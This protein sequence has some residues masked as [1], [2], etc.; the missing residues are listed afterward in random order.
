MTS[1]GRSNKVHAPPRATL[2]ALNEGVCQVLDAHG[3]HV[4]NLKRI[5]GRWKFKAVGD[6]PH[7]EVIPGG[8]PLTDFHNTAFE[9]PDAAEVTTGLGL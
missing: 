6:G 8:G 4:G 7:G 3:Q 5:G 9:R 2:I 1:S